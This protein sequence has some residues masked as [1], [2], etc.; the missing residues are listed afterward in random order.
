MM[1][2]RTRARECFEKFLAK[3]SPRQYAGIIPKVKEE[4]VLLR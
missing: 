1:G 2:D 3:A 4:L